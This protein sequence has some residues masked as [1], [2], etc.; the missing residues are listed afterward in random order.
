MAVVLPNYRKGATGWA[1][2]ADY[3]VK[4]LCQGDETLC[5]ALYPGSV[6]A[7]IMF[8]AGRMR[9]AQQK[10]MVDRLDVSPA[11][12]TRKAE[13][14]AVQRRS[15]SDMQAFYD[16]VVRELSGRRIH[17]QAPW[18]ALETI[19][20]AGLARGLQGVFAPDSIILAAGGTKGVAVADDW[21]D[22]AKRFLG[23]Q[24]LSFL[25]GMTEVQSPSLMC[26]HGRHHLEPTNVLFVLDP[27]TGEILPRTGSQTGRAAF[28][29]LLAE[30]HWG[31]FVTGDEITVEWTTKCSCGRLSPHLDRK[32]TRFTE[33]R[34]GDD[35]ISCA[36]VADAHEEALNYLVEMRA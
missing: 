14:E 12:L 35:K 23:V 33:K 20:D 32:I 28:Y 18:S 21:E 11:L 8:L 36:S 16:R 2:Y 13:F 31:G 24:N 27:E 22:K 25:Y 3:Q 26:S 1:R 7:D 6:S 17:M 19:A 30:S 9:A 29:D 4:Y 15:G 5:Y 34:G 10:G